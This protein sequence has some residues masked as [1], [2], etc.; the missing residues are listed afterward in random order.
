MG[1][2][3]G[4]RGAARV[5]LCP[6]CPHAQT[7]PWP[8]LGVLGLP[9][10][11]KPPK[12]GSQDLIPPAANSRHDAGEVEDLSREIGHVAVE[13]DEEGFDDADV[14]GEA[15]REGSNQPINDAH[16]DAAQRHHEEAEEAKDHIDNGHLLK[17]GKLLK[18][19]VEDLGRRRERGV[20]NCPSAQRSPHLTALLWD[21]P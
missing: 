20:S 3:F 10:R 13:E 9:W 5:R 1:R 11:A 2:H 7:Q 17:V 18:K 4:V 6:H 16:E 15:G 12:V 21:H 14:G 19:V 8:P